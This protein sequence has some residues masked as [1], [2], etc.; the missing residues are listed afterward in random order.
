V[1]SKQQ[2]ANEV[3]VLTLVG[4][5]RVALPQWTAG[6]HIDLNLT[7]TLVRQYSLCGEPS[8]RRRYRIAVVKE[9]ASRGG[10]QFIHDRLRVGDKIEVSPPRNNFVLL[11][12]A[13]YIFIAGG[14][15]ITPILPMITQCM[16]VGANWSLLYGGRRRSSMAFLGELAPYGEQVTVAPEDEVGLLDFAE[17][18]SL[19]KDDT[20][21]YC[22]GP[23]ALLSAIESRSLHWPAGALNVERFRPKDLDARIDGS[24]DIELRR[25]GVRLTVCPGKTILETIEEM[26][27]IALHS[28]REGVCGTCQTA[29]LE[30]IPDHRDSVLSQAEKEANQSIMLCVSRSHSKLLVLDI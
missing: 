24:F 30:G 25:S 27:A 15:G 29:V 6:A 22:C 26:G 5:D 11:P 28:C 4:L 12:A 2:A 8:D 3:A 10:S 17:L 16:K 9:R 20:L 23:E 1:E 14:I 18:L 19:P 21:L 13:N 7:N